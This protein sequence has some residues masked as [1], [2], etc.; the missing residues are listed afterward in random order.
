MINW[1]ILPFC[2]W[3]AILNRARGSQLFGYTDST[4]IGRLV[5]ALGMAISVYI[6]SL[7]DGISNIHAVIVFFWTIGALMFWMVPR[8]DAYW[9][10]EIGNDPKH[11]RLWGL[12]TMTLRMLLAAPCIIGLAYLSEHIDKAWL[13]LATAFLAV[14]YLI[15]GY[16]T[17]GANVIR[18]SELAA[19]AILG[20]LVFMT[21][22]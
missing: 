10:A 22:V 3:F 11:S 8:W 5:A 19:G 20:A 9:S 14:P 18:N 6:L 2:I 4:V 15:F 12:A 16:L 1:L 17:P 13:A 21:V 7:F